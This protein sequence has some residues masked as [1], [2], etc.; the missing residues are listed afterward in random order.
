MTYR[1]QAIGY[2]Q[3][4]SLQLI[5]YM[6]VSCRIDVPG[7]FMG[8]GSLLL[9]NVVCNQAP[10]AGWNAPYEIALIILSVLLF[11]AFL[12]WEKDYAKDPIM[13]LS[14]FQAPTFLALIFVV[15]LSYMAFGIGIWYSVAWQ[16]LLRGVSLTQTGLHFIPFG[17]SAILA[18]FVAAWLIPRVAAQWIMAIG[19]G[20]REDHERQY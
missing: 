6:V 7:I 17:L 15:L 5:N 10:S 4:K 19:V 8:L 3:W 12:I 2:T 13:P 18:V 20:F 16:Q 14:I 11:A 9:F 1:R